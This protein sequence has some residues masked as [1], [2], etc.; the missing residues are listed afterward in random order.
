MRKK[1]DLISNNAEQKY[2]LSFDVAIFSGA[3]HLFCD[4]IE[5]KFHFQSV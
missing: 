3:L 2:N 5:L 1:M 4:V